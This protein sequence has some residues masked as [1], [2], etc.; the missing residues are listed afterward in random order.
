M[1]ILSIVLERPHVLSKL[2]KRA[3]LYFFFSSHSPPPFLRRCT[4]TPRSP[5]NFLTGLCAAAPAALTS[6][7]SSSSF[8]FGSFSL[9]LLLF[10]FTN[11]QLSERLLDGQG[12]PGSNSTPG[13]ARPHLLAQP[14]P[15]RKSGCRSGCS[16]NGRNSLSKSAGLEGGLAAVLVKLQPVLSFYH[17]KG[18]NGPGEG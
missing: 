3:L 1:L 2:K 4:L 15:R 14:W 10:F 16:W 11:W 7:L 9:L 5:F 17:Q 8:L 18:A 12:Q 13:P 6:L